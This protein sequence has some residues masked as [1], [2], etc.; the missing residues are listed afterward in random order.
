MNDMN[1]YT[2]QLEGYLGRLSGKIGKHNANLILDWLPKYKATRFRPCDH[3]CLTAVSR[4]KRISEV[5]NHKALDN[6]NE[7]DLIAFR[8]EM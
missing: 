4:L 2:K 7:S 3:R 1:D 6:L 8:L 5:L